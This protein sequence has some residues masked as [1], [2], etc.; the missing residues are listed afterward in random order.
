MP[1]VHN[2]PRACWTSSARSSA[3]AAAMRCSAA[4]SASARASAR[5]WCTWAQ[6]LCEQGSMSRSGASTQSAAHTVH[7]LKGQGSAADMPVAAHA[8][9]AARL[10]DKLRALERQRCGKLLLDCCLRRARLGARLVHLGKFA[11]LGVH[12]RRWVV[13]IDLS[14]AEV[15]FYMLP[16]RR[17]MCSRLN[18]CLAHARSARPSLCCAAVP[19]C[20]TDSMGCTCLSSSARSSAAPRPSAARLPPPPQRAPRRA[21]GP[22]RQKCPISKA[23]CCG[24]RLPCQPS[25]PRHAPRCPHA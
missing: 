11:Q 17:S 14:P 2:R 7:K 1:R 18:H 25:L 19:H 16:R 4:A 9:R 8:Q 15:R 3:S 12:E 22:P 20:C 6:L 24:A 21:L 23:A 10:L 13:E 5:A